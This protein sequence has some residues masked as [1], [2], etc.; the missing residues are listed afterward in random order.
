M[1]STNRTDLSHRRIQEQWDALNDGTGTDQC[2]VEQAQPAE[3]ETVLVLT[4]LC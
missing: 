1:E 4:E 2:P 3:A